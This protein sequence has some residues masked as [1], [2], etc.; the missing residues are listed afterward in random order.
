MG[1][2][3]AITKR[4]SSAV[5]VLK[6]IQL[7]RMSEEF[8]AEL[9]NEI[10]LL[11]ALDHPNIIKPLELFE[12]KRQMFFVMEFCSGGDLYERMPYSEPDAANY[13]NQICSAIRY[14]HSKNVCHRDLKFE[15]IL[16]ESKAPNSVIKLI[17]FGLSKQYVP[18]SK[19]RE[20]V[21]TL[22]SM[23]PEVLEE[24]GYTQSS[25]MWSIGVLAFMLLGSHMPFE[26]R[27]EAY[28]IERIRRGQFSFRKRAWEGVSSEA[29]DFVTKLLQVDPDKRMTAQEAQAHPW[30]DPEGAFEGRRLSGKFVKASSSEDL[31]NIV[32]S[33]KQ[34][35][36]YSKLRKAALMV[37]AHRTE[38]GQ[39]AAIRDAFL[40]IDTS[41]EGTITLEELQTVL[42]NYGMDPDE[43]TDV[44]KGVDVDK[45]GRIGYTEFL[46]ATV[47]AKGLNTEDK[48]LE[49]FDRLDADDSGYITFENLRE[50]LGSAY[51]PE[52]VKQMIASADFKNDGR[53]D[54]E[55][56][57]QLM[58]AKRE[59]EIEVFNSDPQ[60]APDAVLAA[61]ADIE[62][63]AEASPV[64]SFSE[65]K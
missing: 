22:Y 4:G 5:H 33:L 43:I 17:D 13:T 37:V 44:F 2:V 62:T 46:A 47:E 49:A 30:L 11:M 23:S 21:G 25:D 8:R 35:S 36:S 31:E 39:I 56:F 38:G 58:G 7:N 32:N 19:M 18:G 64:A 1:E 60:P 3:A 29:K 20:T 26:H 27:Y 63:S 61:G 16:F 24:R 45:T 52:E 12:R 42:S 14:L 50:I 41:R 51:D 28:V 40:D 34:Y 48:L 54:L 55:E 59:A 53:V 10:N 6:T 9:K 15:N 57:M 65:P